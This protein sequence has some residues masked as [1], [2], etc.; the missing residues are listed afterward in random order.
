MEKNIR[1]ACAV[2]LLLLVLTQGTG[3]ARGDVVRLHVVANSNSPE[4]QR[5]KEGVRDWV[6]SALAPVFTRRSQKEVTAW[7]MAHRDQLAAGAT[8]VLAEAGVTYPVA[9]QFRV[10]NYPLRTYRAA[11][12]PEG[13]YRSLQI[14]LGQGQGRNWWCLLFP[15]LCLVNETVAQVT[16]EEE[17]QPRFWLWDK[18]M[19]FWRWLAKAL[20]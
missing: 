2:F 8:S 17:I 10:E 19:A 16:D 11:V 9:V 12:Y 7:I 18:F 5:L 3:L 14:V 1:S 20:N 15:S 13:K 4:D 6:V